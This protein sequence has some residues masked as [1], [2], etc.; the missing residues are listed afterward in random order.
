MFGVT[1]CMWHYV[2]MVWCGRDVICMTCRSVEWTWRGDGTVMHWLMWRDISYYDVTAGDVGGGSGF[3]F[4]LVWCMKQIIG[5]TQCDVKRCGVLLSMSACVFYT[6]VIWT[7][8]ILVIW[9]HNV[10]LFLNNVRLFWSFNIWVITFYLLF[11]YGSVK[12]I[13]H[14]YDFE[15]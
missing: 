13:S 6:L 9:A 1:S 5:T 12:Q 11:R 3:I 7:W 10:G 4:L 14:Q 15:T 2:S 8:V